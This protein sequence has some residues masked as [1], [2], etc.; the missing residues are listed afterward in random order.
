MNDNTIPSISYLFV[1]TFLLEHSSTRNAHCTLISCSTDLTIPY[2][3]LAYMPDVQATDVAC[4]R[5]YEHLVPSSQ[6][7]HQSIPKHVCHA[8]IGQ[9]PLRML[10][11]ALR[12]MGHGISRNTTLRNASY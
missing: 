2:D 11:E 12:S 9:M 6:H 10:S 8:G 5:L 4:G 7:S 1:P 3:T